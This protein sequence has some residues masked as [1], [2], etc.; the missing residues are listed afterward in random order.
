MSNIKLKINNETCTNTNITISKDLYEQLLQRISVM[1]KK[2]LELSKTKLSSKNSSQKL[3]T[4]II[5]TI[6][7]IKDDF[8]AIP[9]SKESTMAPI[10]K[11]PY[12]KMEK[13]INNPKLEYISLPDN[14]KMNDNTIAQYDN[15]NNVWIFM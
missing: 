2:Y 4:I 14:C 11:I 12:K 15:D 13:Y 1:E 6:Y 5:E 10:I 3:Q 7:H 8:F 9:D